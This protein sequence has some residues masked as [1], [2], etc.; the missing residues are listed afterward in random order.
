MAGVTFIATRK[1]WMAQI[2]LHTA[3]GRK[4][5]HLGL[6][7]DELS[8]AEAYDRSAIYAYIDLYVQW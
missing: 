7:P 2:Y 8:A 4:K 1:R 5:K 6:F 3:D